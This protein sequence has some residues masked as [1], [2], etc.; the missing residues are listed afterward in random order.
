MFI[1]TLVMRPAML[2]RKFGVP[3]L[4]ICRIIR[5]LNFGRQNRSCSRPVAKKL[6]AA[7]A[8]ITMPRQ[9]PSAAPSMLMPITPRNRNS[10]PALNTDI[11]MFS[12]MLVRTRPEMRR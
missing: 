9:V 12:A 1:S 5:K 8:Q 6:S 11:T 2:F 10:S 4:T 7:I 3:H